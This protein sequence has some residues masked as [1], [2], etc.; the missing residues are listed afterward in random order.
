MSKYK[1]ITGQNLRDL[2]GKQVKHL[3]TKQVFTVGQV[4]RNFIT[5]YDK[6][7]IPQLFTPQYMKKQFAVLE[8]AV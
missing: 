4:G 5:L 8:E 6:N 1:Y 7:N 3:P 2:Q